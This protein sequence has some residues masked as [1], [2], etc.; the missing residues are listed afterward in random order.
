MTVRDWIQSRKPSTVRALTARII[1]ALGPDADTDASR[2]ADVCLAAATRCLDALLSAS[3]FERD[4]AIDLLT[5]DA[6]T[7][8]AFE[9]ASESAQSADDVA[10]LAQQ[11]TRLL[12]Q[13]AA[14]RV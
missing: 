6:L 11:G 7:T 3:R 2:T 12:G 8:Y 10:A 4:S 14:Q 1:I 5:V 13:L 9:H